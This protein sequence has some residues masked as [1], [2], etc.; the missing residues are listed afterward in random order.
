MTINGGGLCCQLAGQS[1]VSARALDFLILTAARSG[2][3]REVPW[4]E[5]DL[6]AKVWT[7]PAVK[8]KAGRK[9]RVPLSSR[10]VQI[11]A[12]MVENRSEVVEG[13][14]VFPG[15][16]HGKP[17]SVMALDMPLRRLKSSDTVHGFRSSFRDWG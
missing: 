13:S 6:I 16:K 11:V 14:Y 9:H 1:G 3:V 7:V 8:M 10:A 15:A 2:E 5:L 17:L 12:E 4:G